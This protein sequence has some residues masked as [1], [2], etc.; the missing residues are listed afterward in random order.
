MGSARRIDS[1]GRKAALASRS[2]IGLPQFELED[3]RFRNWAAADGGGDMALAAGV[4]VV[5]DRPRM[6]YRPSH[7]EAA[8]RHPGFVRE[9]AVLPELALMGRQLD[10]SRGAG[11]T[12][13]KERDP[14]HYVD[15]ADDGKVMGVLPLD[16]LPPDAREVY[17]TQLLGI[18]VC[19]GD[20]RLHHCSRRLHDVGGIDSDKFPS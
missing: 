3:E 19:A 5:R 11:E 14:G 17:D 6:S 18:S 4:Q 12:H 8:R 20:Q 2:L 9:P 15:L 13:D 10:R 7:R 1:T 16:Q